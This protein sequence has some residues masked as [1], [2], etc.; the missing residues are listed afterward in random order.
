MKFKLLILILL[1]AITSSAQYSFIWNPSP[2]LNIAGYYFLWGT[3][4]RAYNNTNILSNQTN[5]TILLNS[6]S[7]YYFAVQAYASNGAVSPYSNEVIVTNESAGLFTVVTN[8]GV[9]SGNGGAVTI[10][11]LV[12]PIPTNIIIKKD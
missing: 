11:Q 8:G 5:Y 6:N 7:V 9:L 3:S 4:S 1:V 2:S 10:I 12:L